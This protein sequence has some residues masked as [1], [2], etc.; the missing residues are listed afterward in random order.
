MDAVVID[1]RHTFPVTVSDEQDIVGT[2]IQ[3]QIPCFMKGAQDL[4]GAADKLQA[5]QK[6]PR[7]LSLYV[8]WFCLREPV[9]LFFIRSFRI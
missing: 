3:M 1:Q 6:C 9:F 7:R 2:Y 5:P 8:L 4:K